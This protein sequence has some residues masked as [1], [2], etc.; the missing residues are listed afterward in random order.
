MDLDLVVSVHLINGIRSPFLNLL[1][2]RLVIRHM[3]QRLICTRAFIARLGE[4]FT[5]F[6]V[7]LELLLVY[8]DL[9]LK[10]MLEEELAS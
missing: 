3:K 1:L 5:I 7:N 6:F 2:G 4:P 9:A 8:T 10:V